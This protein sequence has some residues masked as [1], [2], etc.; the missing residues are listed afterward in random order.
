MH[1][2]MNATNSTYFAI[3][4]TKRREFSRFAV[5]AR[6]FLSR[7]AGHFSSPVHRGKVIEE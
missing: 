6:D 3:K 5:K 1:P 4:L 2:G 7:I